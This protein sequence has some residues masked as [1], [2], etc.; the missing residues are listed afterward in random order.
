[1]ESRNFQL[2]LCRQKK[3]NSGDLGLGYRNGK[4]GDS[5]VGYWRMDGNSE[6]VKDYSGNNNDGTKNGAS[7]DE[8]GF[9]EQNLLVW[10]ALMIQSQFQILIN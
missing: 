6:S 3:S 10:T 1:M 5:L 8:N 9:L 2:D 7:T 4:P